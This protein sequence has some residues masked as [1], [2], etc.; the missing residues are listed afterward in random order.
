MVIP[1]L[2]WGTSS[3]DGEQLGSLS[4]DKGGVVEKRAFA[5]DVLP[6]DAFRAEFMGR[7]WGVPSETL[8]Y[9]R[10]Y[11]TPQL[12]SITLLHHVLVRPNPTHLPMISGIWRLYDRFGMKEATWYPYWSNS[13]I[14]KTGSDRV[15]VSAFRHPK[16]GLLLL[17]S[18]LSAEGG[19]AQVQF[20]VQR[21]GLN[22]EG[23]KAHDPISSEA[24]PLSRDQIN[25]E[26]EPFSFR[27]VWIE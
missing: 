27:Y 25:F 21:L 16:N 14:F 24:I 20:D 3:W 5:L 26:M 4:W 19:Q 8:C 6:L 12:L 17:V 13:D 23:L 7:Q 22:P 9:E 11:S 2:G 15:K 1:T 10:P 18:N